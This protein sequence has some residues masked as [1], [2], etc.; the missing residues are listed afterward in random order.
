MPKAQKFSFVTSSLPTYT[1]MNP[2]IITATVFNK[3]ETA[4][5]VT[6]LD[7]IKNAEF[8]NNYSN[9]TVWQAGGGCSFSAQGT[10]VFS[11]RTLQTGRV[12]IQKSYCYEDLEKFFTYAYLKQNKSLQGESIAG[13][14]EQL[15]LKQLLADIGAN[16]ELSLWQGVNGGANA[17]TALNMY[18]GFLTVTNN[19]QGYV[20]GSTSGISKTTAVG[21]FQTYYQAIPT[22][23]LTVDDYQT[24]TG[25]DAYNDYVI[26][27]VNNNLFNPSAVDNG[28]YRFQI[29]GSN[30]WVK[31]VHGLDT[32][33]KIYGAR[34]ANMFRGIDGVSDMTASQI[35][36]DN[37]GKTT[38]LEI[39]FKTGTQVSILGDI[40]LFQ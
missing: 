18:D 9:T 16:Y 29:Y 13:S 2:D 23:L 14:L 4:D 10:D 12:K 5:M 32:L 22:R 39:D 31:A 6:T 8:V 11:Q 27:L 36:L 3:S 37:N 19:A 30:V 24:F 35:W 1:Q 34:E 25:Y 15:V 7:G 21:I 28:K 38:N 40:V 33:N 20:S 26:N 17:N